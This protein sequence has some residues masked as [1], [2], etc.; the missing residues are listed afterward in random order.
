MASYDTYLSD[1][2][3]AVLEVYGRENAIAFGNRPAL[4]IVDATYAFVGEA[5]EATWE[6][7]RKRRTACGHPA[8]HAI[9]ALAPVIQM[10]RN[11]GVPVIYTKGA[12]RPDLLAHGARSL[13]KTR[14]ANSPSTNLRNGND[15][16]D[17]ISPSTSDIVIAKEK[18]SAFFGTPLLSYLI[19][20]GVDSLF[21]AGGAT[22]GCV[23]ASVVDAFSNNYP[24]WLLQDCCFDR[25]EASHTMTL[26]DLG[27]KYAVIKSSSEALELLDS[28]PI[29][30]LV[31]PRRSTEAGPS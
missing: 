12:E 11:R 14:Q 24:C 18:P 27:A 31:A 26:F 25:F 29:L 30:S 6:A 1:S 13:K 5:R 20:L 15:I 21:I 16:V 7:A 19:A 2:D 8:W 4:L 10:A 23:R 9:D 28:A 17:E 3:K 22:S